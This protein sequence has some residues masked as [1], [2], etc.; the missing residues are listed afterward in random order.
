MDQKWRRKNR[1]KTTNSGNKKLPIKGDLKEIR[2]IVPKATKKRKPKNTT[3][4]ASNKVG[5]KRQKSPK[6]DVEKKSKKGRK[7]TTITK[8]ETNTT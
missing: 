8:K 6:N 3:K 7:K 5:E 1:Q 2:K 4:N